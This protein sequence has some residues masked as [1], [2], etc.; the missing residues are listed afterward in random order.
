MKDNQN[1]VKSIVKKGVSNKT[2]RIKKRIVFLVFFFNSFNLFPHS[3]Q[4][5]YCVSCD[6]DLRIWLEHWHGNSDPNS[7][8]MTI[9]VTVNGT[10]STI[11]SVPGGSVTGMTS[12]SLPGCST[13]ITY[14]VGC[15]TEENT[16]NDWVYYDFPGLPANVPLSFTV[17]I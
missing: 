4:V 3:V 1:L 9:S 6:G 13:P 10:T 11:T 8:T 17:I 7:T 12:G 5:Q 2:L 14:A 16:Y 15:P